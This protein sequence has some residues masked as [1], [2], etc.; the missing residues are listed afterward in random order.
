MEPIYEKV[1][2]T[3]LKVTKPV[4]IAEETKEYDLDFLESQE[5]AILK[6]RDDF[7]LARDLELLEVREL[8]AKCKELG[9]Q[10]KALMEAEEI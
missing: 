2:D 5:E 6:Q 8:I 10:S 4:E 3:T 9:V 7:V 1:D